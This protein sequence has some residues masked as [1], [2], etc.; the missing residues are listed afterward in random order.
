MWDT[1]AGTLVSFTFPIEVSETGTSR[2]PAK[3]RQLQE[4]GLELEASVA[5]SRCTVLCEILKPARGQVS[6]T[7]TGWEVCSA[8]V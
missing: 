7:Q 5:L 8:S 2:L 6:N 4:T 1:R 3:T